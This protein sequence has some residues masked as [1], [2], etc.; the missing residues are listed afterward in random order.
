VTAMRVTAGEAVV[1]AEQLA[2]GRINIEGKIYTV[3]QMT[4]GTWRVMVGNIS[5]RV[6]IAGSGD[7]PWIYCNG[8]VYRP[9]VVDAAQH[10]RPV[11]REDHASLAAPMP[12][13][14]RAV[15][16]SPGQRVSRGDT[17]IVLEAMKM[18]L[19][20]RAP[21]DGT[22]TEVRCAPGELVQPGEPLVEI[23]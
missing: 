21:A 11:R 15:L 2:E 17:I 6:W 16:I 23:Q 7:V 13:T 1:I 18:E 14:V 12:A 3:E 19:P 20:L 4:P 22:V 5:Q 9:E 8:R 10:S